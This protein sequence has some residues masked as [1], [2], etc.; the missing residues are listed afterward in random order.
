V[1][2]AAAEKQS[3]T[4]FN[5][6]A[7]TM[8]EIHFTDLTI[9]G[10]SSSRAPRRDGHNKEGKDQFVITFSLSSQAKG[11][12]VETFNRVWAERG[13]QT[14][15]LNLPVVSDDQIQITCP[16]DDQ[17]QLHLDNLKRMVALTNQVYREF[18]Q[19]ADEE[20]QYQDGILQRLRF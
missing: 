19:A 5:R 3:L 12:W 11:P 7:E 13:K 18:L 20:K 15:P 10:N 14:S 8:S 9:T 6:E 4:R 17:L 1:E 16:F 2:S